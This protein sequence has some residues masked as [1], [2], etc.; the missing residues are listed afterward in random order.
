ML[1]SPVYIKT[2][3]LLHFLFLNKNILI[4]ANEFFSYLLSLPIKDY[5]CNIKYSITKVLMIF[6]IKNGS[7]LVSKKI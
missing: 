5:F 1:F 4:S 3:F 7:K 6:G 2:I